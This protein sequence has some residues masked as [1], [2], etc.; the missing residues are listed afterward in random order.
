MRNPLLDRHQRARF[1]SAAPR[2]EE[3]AIVQRAINLRLVA[4]TAFLG[5]GS[6][7]V[8]AGCGTGHLARL[9][10][11]VWPDASIVGI[12]HAPGMIAEAERRAAGQPNLRFACADILSY[13]PP[14]PFDFLASANA[15][16][17]IQP[18]EDGLRALAAMASRGAG[19]AF[20][21]MLD[22]T[23]RELRTARALAVPDNPP[24]A[25]M[26]SDDAVCAALEKHRFRLMMHDEQEHV[27]YAPDVRHLMQLIRDLGVT[28]GPLGQGRRSLSRRELSKLMTIYEDRFRDAG[29]IP[30][31]YRAGYYW[32]IYDP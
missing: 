17:W 9:L 18:F 4:G 26:P 10:A 19:F 28:G 8:D 2:Y 15:L 21:V 7:V 23:L 1:S 16:H 6:R 31:T 32:G 14:A 12:D 30:A 27:L 13:K 20:A 29:G 3:A 25:G 5:A 11:A 22:G 24:A